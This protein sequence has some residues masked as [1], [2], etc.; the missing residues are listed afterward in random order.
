[1]IPPKN[2]MTEAERNELEERSARRWREMEE[3]NTRHL[4]KAFEGVPKHPPKPVYR[5]AI[6][7]PPISPA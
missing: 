6:D 4:L 3:T 5:P 1:M 2:L 7:S